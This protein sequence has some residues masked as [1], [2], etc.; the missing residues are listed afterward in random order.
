MTRE[1]LVFLPRHCATP[2][3]VIVHNLHIDCIPGLPPET[4]AILVVHSNAVL[5]RACSS[6]CLQAVAGRNPKV[7][8]RNCRVQDRQLLE[9]SMLEIGRKTALAMQP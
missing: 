7:V 8:K 9:C 6:K 2:L 4:H 1:H 5:S 3:S